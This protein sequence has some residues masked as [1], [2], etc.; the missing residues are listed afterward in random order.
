MY[1]KIFIL[2]TLISLSTVS[3]AAPHAGGNH[4]GASESKGLAGANANEAQQV[5]TANSAGNAAQQVAPA[6]GAAQAAT[7]AAQVNPVRRRNKRRRNKGRGAQGG[8][9]A[10]CNNDAGAQA[11]DA[12]AQGADAQAGQQQVAT[13]NEVPADAVII[14][15]SV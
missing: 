5:A 3:L 15:A 11:A 10:P 4:G 1:S 7:G 6:T 13:S 2:F 14:Q 12:G 9:K 8:S